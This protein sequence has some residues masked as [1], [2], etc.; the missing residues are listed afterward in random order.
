MND[1]TQLT[2]QQLRK[3]A[4][5]QD[6]I[7]ALQKEL[8]RVLGGE[9]P[10]PFVKPAAPGKP[11]GRKKRKLSPD[12][13]AAIRAGVAKR[14]ARQAGK[15]VEATGKAGEAPKKRRKIS[16]AGRKALSLAAKARWAKAKAEGKT[17][18]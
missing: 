8:A 9:I 1:I 16:A 5:I 10:S 7:G 4:D 2:G 3:A 6:K 15:K 14:V 12:G 11:K 18:L 13:L 17:K